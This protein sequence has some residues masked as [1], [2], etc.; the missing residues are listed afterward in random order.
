MLM[1]FVEKYPYVVLVGCLWA[2][3]IVLVVIFIQR[4]SIGNDDEW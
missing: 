4:A 3:L 2:L 1:G